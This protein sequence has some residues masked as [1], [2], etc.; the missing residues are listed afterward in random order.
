MLIIYTCIEAINN[1]FIQVLTNS[2]NYFMENTTH[3][4]KKDTIVQMQWISLTYEFFLD[5]NIDEELRNH[6]K[7]LSLIDSS[8][9]SPL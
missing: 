8:E 9:L 3:F 4:G 6:T 1:C 5:Y 7:K 2:N